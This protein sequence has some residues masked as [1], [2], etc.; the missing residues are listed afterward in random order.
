MLIRK[1]IRVS[2]F[3]IGLR[4]LVTDDFK[5]ACKALQKEGFEDLYSDTPLGLAGY[6]MVNGFATFFCIVTI[7]ESLIRTLKTMSHEVF[8]VTQDILEYNEIYFKKKDANEIYA[9]TYE[10]L[11]GEAYVITVN[12]WNK[13]YGKKHEEGRTN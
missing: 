8:H 10:F 7:D 13:K 6:Q 5:S 11:F 4:F 3:D 1:K 2:N 12:A 9:H